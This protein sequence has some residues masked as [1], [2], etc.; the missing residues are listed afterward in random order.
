M[1]APKWRLFDE[2]RIDALLYFHKCSILPEYGECIK[3]EFDASIR[4]AVIE[5]TDEIKTMNTDHYITSALHRIRNR[6]GLTDKPG[7][8]KD[9]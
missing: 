7:E 3:D 9:G 5:V 1:S 2:R 8:G 4:K 6:Y